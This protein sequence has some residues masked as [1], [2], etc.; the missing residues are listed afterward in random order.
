MQIPPNCS[1]RVRFIMQGHACRTGDYYD[2]TCLFICIYPPV[3]GE[4]LLHAHTRTRV[5]LY[6]GSPEMNALVHVMMGPPEG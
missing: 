5:S 6:S 4:M 2:V 3:L 1:A